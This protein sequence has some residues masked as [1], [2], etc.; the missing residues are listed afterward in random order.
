[1]NTDPQPKTTTAPGRKAIVALRILIVFM[2]L[3][4]LFNVNRLL[5]QHRVHF[6]REEGSGRRTIMIDGAFQLPRSPGDEQ[7]NLGKGKIG[8]WE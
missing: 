2:M 1:M 3:V 7:N 5:N 8:I 6:G 4:T